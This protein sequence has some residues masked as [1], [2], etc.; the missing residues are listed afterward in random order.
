MD[1][2]FDVEG[3]TFRWD[4][5]K[6]ESNFVKHGVT[7]EQAA[8]AFLD[9]W[10]AIVD[11]STDGENRKAL[12]AKDRMHRMLYVVHIEFEGSHIRL[13]SARQATAHERKQYG[14]L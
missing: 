12:I 7:F 8:W 5:T 3:E 1:F 13:I 6:A 2:E 14:D 11:A 4:L 9:P 10:F